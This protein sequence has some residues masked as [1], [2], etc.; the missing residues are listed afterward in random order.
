MTIE[1][2]NAYSIISSNSTVSDA[3]RFLRISDD[4]QTVYVQSWGSMEFPHIL[5]CSSFTEDYSLVQRGED[6]EEYQTYLK[7]KEKFE[8]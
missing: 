5:S 4:F 8:G 6:S 1:H 3:T 7:L 2:I